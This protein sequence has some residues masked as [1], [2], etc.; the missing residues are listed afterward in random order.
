MYYKN[1]TMILKKDWDY[2]EYYSGYVVGD[3]GSTEAAE[4]WGGSDSIKLEYLENKFEDIRIIGLSVRGNGGR[5]YR[6]IIKVNHYNVLVDLR[7]DILLKIIDEVGILPKG[8]VKGQFSFYANSSQVQLGFVNTEEDLEQYKSDIELINNLQNKQLK[9][10]IKLKDLKVGYTYQI[11]PKS[12]IETKRFYMYFGNYLDFN[13]NKLKPLILKSTNLK[14]DNAHTNYLF[15][16]FDVNIKSFY[17]EIKDM[18]S[19][20]IQLNLPYRFII[21][22]IEKTL[23]VLNEFLNNSFE[24]RYY[25]KTYDISNTYKTLFEYLNYVNEDKNYIFFT[26]NMIYEF[27][28]LFDSII[29]IEDMVMNNINSINIDI[30]SPYIINQHNSFKDTVIKFFIQTK[31]LK[32]KI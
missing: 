13:D 17:K 20:N 22:Q 10:T 26:E 25:Y 29:E 23:A 6:V 2:P 11:V 32:N 31:H 27:K 12:K 9:N 7:E 5:A 19:Y 16:N 24:D 30:N 15:Q 8:V 3:N 18:D 14:D 28:Q 4:K 21:K 1:V